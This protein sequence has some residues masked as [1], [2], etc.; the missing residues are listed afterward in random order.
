[1]AKNYT[2]EDVKNVFLLNKARNT[3]YLEYYKNYIQYVM[4]RQMELDKDEATEWMS[5]VKS[6]TTFFLS[7]TLY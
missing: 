4:D 6:P 3:T 7:S 2:F 5:N 1:M